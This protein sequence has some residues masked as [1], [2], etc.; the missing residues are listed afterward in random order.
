MGG[1]IKKGLK[2]E[3]VGGRGADRVQG[4]TMYAKEQWVSVVLA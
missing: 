4:V 3:S 2:E 1:M